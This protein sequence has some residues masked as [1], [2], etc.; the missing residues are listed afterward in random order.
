MLGLFF[1]GVVLAAEPK[2]PERYMQELLAVEK[3]LDAKLQAL[4]EKLKRLEQLEAA[5]AATASQSE[6]ALP[7]K[8]VQTALA[9]AG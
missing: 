6:H 7:E 2:D 1:S 3:R 5:Q 8:D 4:D 9:Q